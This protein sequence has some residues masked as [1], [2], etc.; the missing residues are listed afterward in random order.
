MRLHLQLF[1]LFLISLSATICK[2]HEIRPGFLQIQQQSSTTY[3]VLWK[4]PRTTDKVLNV[5]PEFDAAFTLKETSTPKLLEAFM[6]YV[7]QLDGKKSLANTSLRIN[8]LSTT[9][10]DVL[11]DIRFLNG[12]HHTFLLQPT[13][14]TVIIP[15]SQNSWQVVKTYT[16]LGV[17]HILLGFDHL[18][19]V[20]ALLIITVGFSKLLK[21]ITAFTIA[22][23]ITLSF[24]V[25][26][27]ASLPGPPVEAAIAL[28]IVF[29]AVEIL[30]VQQNKPTITSEKPWLVA[31]CFGLLHGFGFAGALESIGLPQS[32]VPLALAMFNIGVELGQIAFVTVA[33]LIMHF[34]KNIIPQNKYTKKIVPYFIGSLAAFWLI[35]RIAG[36]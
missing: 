11:V 33:L 18:L 29:L 32:E 8:N 31:F 30:K 17:E 36:F 23:S 16:I 34:S 5:Q 28:S 9:R 20:L 26:G 22:H 2:A 10:I 13:N 21:T 7:Y 35:E 15:E 19:F 27:I 6:L 25:L 3:S 12:E 14:N 1:Y 4:V 24:S